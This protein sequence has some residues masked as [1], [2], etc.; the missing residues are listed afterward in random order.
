MVDFIPARVDSESPIYQLFDRELY[1][2]F[3]FSEKYPSTYAD[4]A[5]RSVGGM[6]PYVNFLHK[7]LENNYQGW[8]VAKG[9]A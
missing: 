1:E 9:R 8:N 4:L 2:D 7:S 6:V 3:T 5:H